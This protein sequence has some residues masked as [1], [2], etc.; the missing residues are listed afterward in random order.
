MG[1]GENSTL[2]S[3]N[4]LSSKY[5]GGENKNPH[6]LQNMKRKKRILSDNY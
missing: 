6:I 1:Q 3:E 2:K 5:G 4:T